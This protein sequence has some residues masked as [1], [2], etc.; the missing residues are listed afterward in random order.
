MR[1]GWLAPRALPGPPA[2]QGTWAFQEGPA[3]GVNPADQAWMASVPAGPRETGAPLGPWDP[4]V[5]LA[6]THTHTHTCEYEG[7][8]PNV[9]SLSPG[10]HG[11]PGPP[12]PPGPGL[13]GSKGSKG[14]RG[15]LGSPG[16]RGNHGTRGQ[17]VSKL[18]SKLATPISELV[19]KFGVR[20]ELVRGYVG[21]VS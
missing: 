19:S 2:P 14:A 20:L 8:W 10:H 3:R 18:C 1:W 16:C 7:P 5:G 11:P 15:L 17:Q 12:G 9:T 21:G 4:K 6:H 13:K